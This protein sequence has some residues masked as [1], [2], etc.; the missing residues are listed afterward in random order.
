MLGRVHNGRYAGRW[1]QWPWNVIPSLFNRTDYRDVRELVVP[2][3][4][5][6]TQRLT[7]IEPESLLRSGKFFQNIQHIACLQLAESKSR[8]PKPQRSLYEL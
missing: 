6:I 4:L 1:G 2:E 8:R 7:R 3:N 5:P